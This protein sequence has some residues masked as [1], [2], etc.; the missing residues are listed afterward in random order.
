MI[1]FLVDQKNDGVLRIQEIHHRVKNNLTMLQS[2]FFLQAK[3]TENED[4][5]LALAE[6]QTR[7][8]S[9]A[10]V[11]N[12]LYENEGDGG[13]EVVAFV[14]TLLH[15]ISETFVNTKHKPVSFFVT[16]SDVEIGIKLAIPVG[17]I[18]NELITNSLKYAFNHVDSGRIDV[19]VS[20]TGSMLNI[21][22]SD[23]G[24]GLDKEFD[25]SS[26]GFGFK[27]LKLLTKQLKANISYSK[28]SDFSKFELNIPM[29]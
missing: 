16:G 14:Q 24:P 21:A 15:D 2:L 9:M 17:L 26:A 20:H 1:R 29:E 19:V 6:S 3:S 18:L 10:V 23:N 22:Y 28:G 7:L 11:H 25:L 13:L 12:H 4:L 5:R 8:L 27:I